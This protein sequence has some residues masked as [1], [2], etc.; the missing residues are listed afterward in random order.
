M[1]RY[2]EAVLIGVAK[3]ILLEI[4]PA[5]HPVYAPPK[6]LEFVP[7]SIFVT[8]I[9]QGSEAGGLLAGL[10][11]GCPGGSLGKNAHRGEFRTLL[12]GARKPQEEFDFR[13]REQR[14]IVILR[15]KARIAEV[16]ALLAAAGE[17]G[18]E[19]VVQA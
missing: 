4:L 16:H 9:A 19:I 18:I 8:R 11:R 5:V 14:E 10:L 12:Y 6:D 13:L 17:T 7:H 3:D 1:R 15:G 2:G